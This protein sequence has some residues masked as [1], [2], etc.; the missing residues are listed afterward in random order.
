MSVSP[1][2]PPY[3]SGIALAIKPLSISTFCQ[4]DLEILF[5]PDELSK[6]IPLYSLQKF[7]TSS[8]KSSYSGPYSR[9]I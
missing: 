1:P 6:E 3:S 9:F 8:L 7:I 5:L 4:S 2:K